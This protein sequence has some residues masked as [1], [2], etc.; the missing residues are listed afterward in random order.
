MTFELVLATSKFVSQD[1]LLRL[2]LWRGW[3]DCLVR[4][5]V[6]RGVLHYINESPYKGSTTRMRVYVCA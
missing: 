6:R 3:E 4:V 2:R 1:L 5:R